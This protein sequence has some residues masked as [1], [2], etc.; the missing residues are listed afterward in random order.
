MHDWTNEVT[1][2]NGEKAT[3]KYYNLTDDKIQKQIDIDISLSDI[4]VS[5]YYDEKGLLKH[6]WSKECGRQ[7]YREQQTQE[8]EHKENK[9]MK[10][11]TKKQLEIKMYYGTKDLSKED[12]K[13]AVNFL[14]ENNL[15][16]FAKEPKTFKAFV[17]IVTIGGENKKLYYVTDFHLTENI[18]EAKLF[19]QSEEKDG[20][21]YE[22]VSKLV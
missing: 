18:E 11:I 19:E 22:L 12:V 20:Y 21:A 14:E 4:S 1:L 6:A 3:Y 13:Q 17:K 10:T 5:L 16:E 7:D 2:D 8:L 9:E 15:I